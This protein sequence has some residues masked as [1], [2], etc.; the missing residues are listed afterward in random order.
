MS[1]EA[2]E[3]EWYIEYL[4]TGHELLWDRPF[5]CLWSTLSANEAVGTGVL[6]GRHR[7]WIAPDGALSIARFTFG[8]NSLDAARI[9]FGA[10]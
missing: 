4:S 1:T 10:F 3:T 9:A 6:V 2:L 5:V 8:I 7:W